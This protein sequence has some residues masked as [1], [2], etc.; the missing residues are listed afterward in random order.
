MTRA[1]IA[2]GSN[3]RPAENIH[4]ALAMLATRVRVAA[5]SMV[6]QTDAIGRPEQEPYY[7]CV[8][9]IE[10]DV[11]P[12]ELKRDVLRPIEDRLGRTRGADKYAPRTMDL[13]LIVYGDLVVDE[14]GMHLPDAEILERP[15]LAIAL[16]E[17]APD[18]VLAGSN[19]RVADVAAALPGRR[20]LPLEDYAQ[21]LQRE[22]GRAPPG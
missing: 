20:M 22:F 1:F 10:A 13:D 5:V 21:R 16:F 18:W 2:M 3:I 4:R 6:Y 11:S 19:R 9:E 15:F 8:V 14:D 17:L 7:N 12:R